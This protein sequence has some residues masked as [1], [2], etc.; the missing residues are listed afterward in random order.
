MPDKP[1][2][3]LW[4]EAGA[5]G[6]LPVAPGWPG[7]YGV[8]PALR[9]GERSTPCPFCGWMR[10]CEGCE[11]GE[12]DVGLFGVI[13]PPPGGTKGVVSP[14]R[15]ETSLA[16]VR[17]SVVEVLLTGDTLDA[18]TLLFA[19]DEVG[20]EVVAEVPEAEGLL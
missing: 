19:V 5:V 12:P 6:I 16:E 14:G 15:A 2:T 1:G 8:I 13:G 11:S 18:T 7:L 17:G 3:L 10:G 20:L 4:G 9:S